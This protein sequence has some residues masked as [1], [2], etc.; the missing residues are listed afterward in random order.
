MRG[1][2]L[3]TVS[4]LL[5]APVVAGTR[6]RGGSAGSARGAT[7]F[8][9]EQIGAVRDAGVGAT[10]IVRMDSAFYGAQVIAACREYDAPFSVTAKLDPKVKEAIAAIAEDAWTPIKYPRRHFRPPSR[11]MGL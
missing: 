1:L 4:T 2:L 3:A 9:R 5:A 8:V 7:S 6:L 10:L 11:W